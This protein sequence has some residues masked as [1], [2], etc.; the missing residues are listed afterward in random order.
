MAVEQTVWLYEG[1]R[2][3]CAVIHDIEEVDGVLTVCHALSR[4]AHHGGAVGFEVANVAVR[5]SNLDRPIHALRIV[6]PIHRRGVRAAVVRPGDALFVQR[7]ADRADMA[8][9]GGCVRVREE[10]N[11]WNTGT[12]GTGNEGERKKGGLTPALSDLEQS[13]AQ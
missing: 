5:L 1:D 3:Q 6:L 9:R 12:S 11:K 2:R 4:I 10:R 7:F 8:R 13:D